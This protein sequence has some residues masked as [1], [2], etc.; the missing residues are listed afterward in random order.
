MKKDQKSDQQ[1]SA[2]SCGSWSTFG[3]SVSN[4]VL[5]SPKKIESTDF[6]PHT[7]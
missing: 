2:A 6:R 1:A 5:H 7:G 3:I 4:V